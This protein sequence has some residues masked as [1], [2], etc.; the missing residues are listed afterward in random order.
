[1]IRT[2]ASSNFEHLAAYDEQLLRLG[3]LAERYFPEDPNTAT[4]KLRQLT[5]LTRGHFKEF[6]QAFGKDPLGEPASLKKRKD[7]G[8]DGRFRKFTREWIA[9]RGVQSSVANA[10]RRE[11]EQTPDLRLDTQDDGFHL[12]TVGADGRDAFALR[13]DIVICRGTEVVAVL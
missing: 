10:L 13:P 12:A 1:M 2:T 7:T 6:E 9:E 4:L 5:Q 3:M 11:F 8:E